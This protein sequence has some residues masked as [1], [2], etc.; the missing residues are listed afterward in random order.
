M[1]INRVIDDE[2]S[3]NISGAI[4]K[5]LLGDQPYVVGCYFW[6][7]EGFNWI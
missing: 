3:R 7:N 1:V 2:T 6:G 4:D 5:H